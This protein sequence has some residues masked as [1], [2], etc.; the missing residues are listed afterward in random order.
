MSIIGKFAKFKLYKKIFTWV[1]DWYLSRR[2]QKIP[3]KRVA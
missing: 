1:K 2:H 3:S